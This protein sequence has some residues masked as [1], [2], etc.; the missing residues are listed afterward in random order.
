MTEYVSEI[1]FGAESHP[2]PECCSFKKQP[3]DVLWSVRTESLCRRSA[4]KILNG[5]IS[6]EYRE[7]DYRQHHCPYPHRNMHR[8]V[9]HNK[10]SAH[11][12]ILRHYHPAEQ[13]T[14]YDAQH[15]PC[16]GNDNRIRSVMPYYPFVP[17]T[18]RLERTYLRFLTDSDPVHGGY[19]RQYRYRKEEYRQDRSHRFALVHLASGFC[20]RY[21]LIFCKYEQGASESFVYGCLYLLLVHGR[22]YIHLAENFIAGLLGSN[23]HDIVIDIG[24]LFSYLLFD[25]LPQHCRGGI[26][27][28][29]CIE[30][31]HHLRLIANADEIF[32]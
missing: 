26:D 15:R 5:Q 29:V 2:A 23:A 14:Q 18:E 13:I 8:P 17:E 19:H 31:R 6:H 30:V 21:I 27:V 22:V 32:C 20:I 10:I 9:R 4:K 28:S 3:V 25:H 7:Q 12:A 11:H 24:F 1:P 16:K